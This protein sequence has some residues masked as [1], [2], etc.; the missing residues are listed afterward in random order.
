M[1]EGD[2]PSSKKSPSAP[3]GAHEPFGS[4]RS[5]DPIIHLDA[6]SPNTHDKSTVS[7][8][9]K[10]KKQIL[11]ESDTSKNTYHNTDFITHQ[12]NHSIPDYYSDSD[13]DLDSSFPIKP[14]FK[15]SVY[16][17]KKKK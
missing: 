12:P 5:D 7:Q 17:I 15:S 3:I 6:L 8:I 9:N 4:S 10:N 2:S 1:S 13:S 14:H 11:I 16:D